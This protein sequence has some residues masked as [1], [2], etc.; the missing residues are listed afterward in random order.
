MR[1]IC[2][3]DLGKVLNRQQS[4][5][6]NVQGNIIG[7]CTKIRQRW[8]AYFKGLLNGNIND[9]EG[10]INEFSDANED[11]HPVECPTLEEVSDALGALKKHKDPGTDNIPAELLKY[12]GNKFINA[13]YN[14]ITLILDLEQIPDEWRKA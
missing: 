12:G 4:C 14:L 5:A 10:E 7:D 6:K 13:I 9:E 8:K 3:N 2:I 11:L 1:M